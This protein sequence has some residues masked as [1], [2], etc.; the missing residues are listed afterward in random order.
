M[1]LATVAFTVMVSLVKVGRTELGF[2]A[3]ELMVWRALGGFPLLLV[4]TGFALGVRRVDLLAL[5]CVAGFAAMYSFFSAA[6]GLGVGEM[7]VIVK[8]QPILVAL[9][10]PLALGV[11]ERSDRRGVIALLLGMS[12]TLALLWPDLREARLTEHVEGALWALAAACFSAVA[13][14]TLRALGSTEEPKVVVFW[15]QASTGALALLLVGARGEGKVP[16]SGVEWGVVLGVGVA[17]ALGQLMMTRAYQLDRAARVAAA[18]Y[19]APLFGFA[20][21]IAFFGAVPGPHAV[22]GTALVLGAGL[23]VL[24]SP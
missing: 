8:L 6:K 5:R 22:V 18:S 23:L 3:L 2:D 4:I 10:A 12:G 17:A 15:F 19:A 21:D 24:R 16:V 20:V 1:V 11:S 13:H 9:L 14:T 7:S